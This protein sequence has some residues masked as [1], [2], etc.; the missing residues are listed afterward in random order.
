[1]RAIITAFVS[2]FLV[3]CTTTVSTTA[4]QAPPAQTAYVKTSPPATEARPVTETL[5]GVEVTDPYRWLEDQQSP[6]TRAWID[7]QNAY[8]DAM[9][10]SLPERAR[11]APRIAALLDVEQV[12][13]PRVRGGRYF[14][15]KRKAGEDLFSIYMRERADGP[16]ILL[17]DPAPM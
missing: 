13:T 12:S 7:R 6:E 9:I 3:A 1:M 17:I 14:F 4:P 5:H 15:T 10:G 2:L 8:T 16:D 11:F